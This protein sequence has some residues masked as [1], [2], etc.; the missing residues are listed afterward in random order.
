MYLAALAGGPARDEAV[1]GAAAKVLVYLYPDEA[2]HIDAVAREAANPGSP[3]FA[4]G[5]L[6]AVWS[7]RAPS[8]TAPT[9]SGP[10]RHPRVPASGCR[11]RQPSCRPRSS[12]SRGGGRP[13][14][15]TPAGNF[16]RGGR[17]PHR[18]STSLTAEQKRIAE[19][20]SDGAGTV[21]PPG[22][23]NVIALGLLREAN[24]STLRSA[25]LLAALNTAQ[26]DAFIA[27]WDAKFTY[28]SLRP[29]T[30]IRQLIDPGWLSYIVNPAVPVVRLRPLH[31]IGCRLDRARRFLS[32]QGWGTRR[33]G[34]GGRKLAPLRRHPFPQR[35]R[36]RAR[37]R[38]ACRRR[39]GPRI[40]R[41]PS[42]SV[43][44]PAWT[45]KH[46]NFASDRSCVRL[47]AHSCVQQ[48]L[49]RVRGSRWH[50]GTH[51]ASAA[52]HVLT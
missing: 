35:Q 37:A 28:W 47:A 27:C 1:S 45:R 40:P 5:G 25:W 16:A 46:K 32:P 20:W 17:S 24:W 15:W 36:R 6:S 2:W 41:Q 29:V 8:R 33:D 43:G 14:T 11:R 51:H 22:H 7:S 21:T 49:Y 38:T 23:W 19:F 52:D 3:A 42:L 44:R 30:A 10:G 34:R 48:A 18:V 31:D 26:P 9:P 50:R 39:R 4:F 13:G 12:R